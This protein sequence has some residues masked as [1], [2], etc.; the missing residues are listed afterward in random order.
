MDVEECMDMD[1]YIL[2]YYYFIQTIQTTGPQTT[3]LTLIN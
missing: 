2:Q 1:M 3:N